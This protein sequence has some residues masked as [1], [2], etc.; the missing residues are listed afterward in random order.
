MLLGRKPAKRIAALCLHIAI[1]RH[2]PPPGEQFSLPRRGVLPD[3]VST[4]T[5]DR[6]R[7]AGGRPRTVRRR[8]DFAVAQVPTSTSR[9]LNRNTTCSR[10][11]NFRIFHALSRWSPGFA[12]QY[13]G[14]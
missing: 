14:I 9:R 7:E 8:T 12:S 3:L 5:R 6:R 11:S 2:R 4:A 1:L 10:R 13:F